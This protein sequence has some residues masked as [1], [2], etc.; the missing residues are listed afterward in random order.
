MTP[1]VVI[2]SYNSA[3]SLPSTLRNA[4]RVS[5]DIHVVD[6]F[7]TDATKEIAEEH[8]ARLIQH[9][10]TNYG[11]QRNWAMTN[12]QLR[13][14]WQLHLDADET[15]S[16]TLAQE[17]RDLPDEPAYDA[18]ILPRMIRFLGSEIRHGGMSP[19]WHLRLFRRGRAHCEERKY[20]QHFAA[21][22]GA[23]TG[24]LKG[25]MTDDVRMPL[26]EWTNRHNRWSDAEVDQ[27]LNGEQPVEI[28]PKLFGNPIERRR[29]YRRIYSA[30]PQF[31]R[32][33]AMFLYRYLILLGF[34][35]G[36]AGLVFWVLQT[37]W[38]RFL[39]DAKLYEASLNGTPQNSQQPADTAVPES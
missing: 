31:V 20:D 17:I 4:Q 30:C 36:K 32:P 9:E 5:D 11:A 25:C 1:S 10:F 29:Y 37:F 15:I 14:P 34:L 33:L 18:Y 35:D 19:T 21:E 13:Y 8:G 28:T 39:I 38:F 2:L 12:L 22:S 16:D 26:T 7:S 6:S 3:A 23:R 27:L 24:R